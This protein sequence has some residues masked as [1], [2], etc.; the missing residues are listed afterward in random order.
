MV[1]VAVHGSSTHT[2]SGQTAVG[3]DRRHPLRDAL[4]L[5]LPLPPSTLGLVLPPHAGHCG[6]LG[7]GRRPFVGGW[8]RRMIHHSR[9]QLPAIAAGSRQ[10]TCNPRLA[11]R[12]QRNGPQASTQAAEGKNVGT[13][14][15]TDT[16]QPLLARG[17]SPGVCRRRPTTRR[18]SP[19]QGGARGESGVAGS[20]ARTGNAHELTSR[21]EGHLRAVAP[22]C[23]LI[24]QRR[25]EKKRRARQAQAGKDRA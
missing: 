17:P 22:R 12:S 19:W 2:G 5:P 10:I 16:S 11:E 14:P 3:G 15:A 9:R 25:G 13:R 4:S 23:Q 1:L 7:C 21:H 20:K 8:K 6:P 18:P 24:H